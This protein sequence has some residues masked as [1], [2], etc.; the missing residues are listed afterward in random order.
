MG[1]RVNI[2]YSVDI[3]E[4]PVEVTRILHGALTEL[5]SAREHAL[6]EVSEDTLM[7]LDTVAEIEAIRTQLSR[8]DFALSDVNNLVN[9]FLNYKTAD[10]AEPPVPPSFANVPAPPGLDMSPDNLETLQ[11]QIEEFKNSL[12][13][14]PPKNEVSD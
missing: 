4:L 11:E 8:I 9:A 12:G 1:Q 13:T 10:S 7:S 5:E 14:E 2:Q 3:E 6:T